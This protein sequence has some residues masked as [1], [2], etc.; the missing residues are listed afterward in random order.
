MFAVELR[1][2]SN[3]LLKLF[4]G[5]FKIQNVEIDHKEKVTYEVFNPIDWKK[6]CVI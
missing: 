3:C 4:N 5:K 6:K 1:F 2:L